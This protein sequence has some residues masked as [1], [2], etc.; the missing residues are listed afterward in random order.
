LIE[1]KADDLEEGMT[2]VTV[3]AYGL[4]KETKIRVVGK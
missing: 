2:V 4:P 3:G 1:V